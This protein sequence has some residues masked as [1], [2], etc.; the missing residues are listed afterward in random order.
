M[1]PRAG[2]DDA[3][4]RKFLTLPGLELPLL[5]RPVRSQSLY[6]LR[7]LG[8]YKPLC[9]EWIISTSERRV[10][11]IA[12]EATSWIIVC[13]QTNDQCILYSLF[14][15]CHRIDHILSCSP[16]LLRAGNQNSE[17]SYCDMSAQSQN[18]TVRRE[19]LL[20][21]GSVNRVPSP[22]HAQA[23]IEELLEALFSMW[24]VPRL[25]TGCLTVNSQSPFLK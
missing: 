17:Y 25:Y 7:Y 23:I 6:R 15:E 14:N 13:R 20:R 9:S 1:S 3:E 16:K 24:S 12:Y 5:R 2:L 18:C 19:P 22:T 8:S 10:K 11:E 21:K 4:K